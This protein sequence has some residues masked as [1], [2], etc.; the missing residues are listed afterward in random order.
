MMNLALNI[1]K[2]RIKAG[3]TEQ[4]FAEYVKI[5]GIPIDHLNDEC[6]LTVADVVKISRILDVKARELFQNPALNEIST[7]D[8]VRELVNREGVAC[9]GAKLK[10]SNRPVATIAILDYE[11]IAQLCSNRFIE[12]SRELACN[13]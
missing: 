2:Y 7:I 5:A 10:H 12:E 6:N 1:E 8:L 11:D 9:H 3:V 13:E 4:E